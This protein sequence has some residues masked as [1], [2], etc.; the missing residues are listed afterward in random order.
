M[1]VKCKSEYSFRSRASISV[2][3]HNKWTSSSAMAETVWAWLTILRG[4][5]I[6]G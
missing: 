5:S 2:S 6:W 1:P 3:L 4:G